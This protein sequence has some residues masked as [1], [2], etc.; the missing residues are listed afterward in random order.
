MEAD[1][2]DIRLAHIPR[3]HGKE[4]PHSENDLQERDWPPRH[5]EEWS[6]PCLT[7]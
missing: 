6:Y 1:A 4:R 3:R 7:E 2:L 5:Y